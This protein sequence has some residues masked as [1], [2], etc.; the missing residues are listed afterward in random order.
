[1]VEGISDSELGTVYLINA[2]AS[3]LS[4]L[5]CLFIIFMYTCC[6]E[7]KKLAFRIIAI[8]SAFDLLNAISF[9]I[10]TYGSGIQDFSCF[11]QGFLMNFSSFA[12]VLW[13]SFVGITLYL[14]F[15]RGY[16][17]IPKVMKWYFFFDLLASALLAT[18]PYFME[19]E[20][21]EGYCWLYRGHS[22]KKYFL[23]FMSFLVPLWGII[24][25]NIYLF[26]SVFRTLRESEGGEIA[27]SR[28]KL[29]VKIGIYP[30]IIVACYMPYTIKGVME[31]QDGFDSDRLEYKL[32]IITG[33]IRCLIGLFN[34]I[35][36]GFT[37]KVKNIIRKKICFSG[38]N[39]PSTL[40]TEYKT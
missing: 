37:K 36:Y 28:R 17:N 9:I 34:A 35:A 4:I 30:V 14:V 33:V 20:V 39:T 2:V 25:V 18:I 26:I 6:R 10:P 1:M 21:N 29:S 8:L 32:T 16:T 13:A 12:A 38:E 15:V 7:L 5:G 22:K 24:F 19:H 31:I 3:V 40:L 27:I 23:R 11:F